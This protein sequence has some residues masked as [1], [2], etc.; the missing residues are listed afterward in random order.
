MKCTM[1]FE[2][3]T[4]G[5]GAPACAEACP[6]EAITF[7]KL[8]DLL[9]LARERIRKAPDEYVDHVYGQHEIGGTGWLYISHV[10]FEEVG[11]PM[12]LG[13]TAYPEYT[14]SALGWIPHIIVLW[15]VVLG[16]VYALARRRDQL[17]DKA[18]RDA[19]AE[20]AE[21][22]RAETKTAADKA[23]ASA[24]KM[25]GKK[26]EREKKAAIKKA[27]DEALAAERAKGDESAGEGGEG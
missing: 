16:G 11:L 10:P 23:K 21:T 3:I 9:G 22:A 25:A 19:A 15:P 5:Q 26:A 6:T 2:K 17:D 13:R 1:C 12:D 24:L 14:K 20:A 7:G 8:S 18:R 27:V 4:S